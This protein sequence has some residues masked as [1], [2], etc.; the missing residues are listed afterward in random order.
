MNHAPDELTTLLA[1]IPLVFLLLCYV[2]RG[3]R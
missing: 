3:D 1:V 2:L